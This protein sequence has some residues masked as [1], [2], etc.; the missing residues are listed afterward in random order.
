MFYL[1]FAGYGPQDVFA[2]EVT[3]AGQRVAARF[4]T[5]ARSVVLANDHRDPLAHPFASVT[6]LNHALDALAEK[7]DTEGDVLFLLLSSHGRQDGTLEVS[8]WPFRF[9]ALTPQALREALDASGIRNRVIV[10]S[11]CY[12]GSFVAPLATPQTMVITASRAD[13]NSF[14]CENG[15]DWTW[16]GQAFFDEAMR[17]HED[18]E[19]VFADAAARVAAREQAEGRLASEPQIIVGDRIRERLGALDVHHGLVAQDGAAHG[20]RLAEAHGR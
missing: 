19:A 14:G 13:R 5:E 6:S 15:A 20:L 12:S 4:G 17:L 7:M 3:S 9:A 10:V 11:S 16:F 2:R 18:L 1:G 8:M